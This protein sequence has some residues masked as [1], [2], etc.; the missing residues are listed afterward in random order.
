MTGWRKRVVNVAWA[1]LVERETAM[2]KAGDYSADYAAR[3]HPREVR[4]G[5]AVRVGGRQEG[6]GPPARV[7]TG[8]S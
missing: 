8:R 1:D 6:T 5:E 2:A 4:R 7:N 3:A